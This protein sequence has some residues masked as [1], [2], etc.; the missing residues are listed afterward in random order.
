MM[1]RWRLLLLR[2]LQVACNH[3]K[4][5]VI[6]SIVPGLERHGFAVSWCKECGAYRLTLEK[7]MVYGDRQS[8]EGKWTVFP[9][10]RPH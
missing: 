8:Q 3:P 10:V 9:W 5:A 6:P 1:R 7:H 4:E 2:M